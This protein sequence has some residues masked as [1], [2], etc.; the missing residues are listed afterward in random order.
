MVNRQRNLFF[1]KKQKTNKQTKNKT[2]T[3]TQNGYIK[4][5]TLK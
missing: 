4:M 5:A 2:Q 3:L 1:K